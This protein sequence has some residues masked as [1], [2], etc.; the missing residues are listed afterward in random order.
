MDLRK[1]NRMIADEFTNNINPVSTLS[2]AAQHLAGK[3]L[4]CKLDCYQAYN[5][6]QMADQ[7]S[8][9]MHAFNFASRTFAYKSLLCLLC[10]VSCVGTWTQL[11]KLTN[12]LNTWP[13]LELP[14]L[15]GTSPETFGQSPSALS[16]QDWNCQLRNA[17]SE[18]NKL[19][20]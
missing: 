11:S 16:T 20:S 18:S 1:T 12:V 15:V 8:V 13:T 17:T 9:E 2:D 14:I 6:L 3:S 19:N 7:R 4:F 5:C 10:R